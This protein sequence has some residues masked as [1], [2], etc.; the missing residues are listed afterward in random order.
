[1][2]PFKEM[3]EGDLKRERY[4]D[5][6]FS[7]FCKYCQALKGYQFYYKGRQVF[8]YELFDW[9]YKDVTK[10]LNNETDIQAVK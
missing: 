2:K 3:S 5:I 8:R 6:P 10:L 9:G 7:P 4:K 1:M